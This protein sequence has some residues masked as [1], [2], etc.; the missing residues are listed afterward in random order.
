MIILFLPVQP[1]QKCLHHLRLAEKQHPYF[2]TQ[3]I[4]GGQVHEFQ[5]HR[6]FQTPRSY[7]LKIGD[8]A[9]EAPMVRNVWS[10][11]FKFYL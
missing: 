11:L 8:E 7:Q 9:L 4:V 1:K 3:D 6:P 2:L 5:V 10:F